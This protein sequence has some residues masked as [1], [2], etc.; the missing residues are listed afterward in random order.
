M[1]DANVFVSVFLSS[2]ARSTV[3]KVLTYVLDEADLLYDERLVDEVI[4][5]FQKDKL[6]RYGLPERVDEV[7][8]LITSSSA[9]QYVPTSSAIIDSRDP[10]DNYILA[11]AFDGGADCVVTGDKDLLVLHPWRGIPIVRPA[12]FLQLVGEGA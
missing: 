7:I 1:L 2:S 3:V 4:K 10:D 12:E 8:W 11:L 5:T 9:S 6:V